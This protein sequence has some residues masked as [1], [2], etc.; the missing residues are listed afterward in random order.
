MMLMSGAEYLKPRETT[1]PSGGK[2]PKCTHVA[3]VD[4]ED[5]DLCGRLNFLHSGSVPA[6]A[7]KE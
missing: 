1:A 5:V 4:V 6:E 2:K 7:E 3:V